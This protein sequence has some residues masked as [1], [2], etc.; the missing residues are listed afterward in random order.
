[1]QVDVSFSSAHSYFELRA[2]L[3]PTQMATA[4]VFRYPQVWIV[5]RPRAS[6]MGTGRSALLQRKTALP[7]SKKIPQSLRTCFRMS[8]LA[9][10]GERLT[11]ANTFV[12]RLSASSWC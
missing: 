1:M 10:R 6:E 8:G 2:A 11:Q 12:G 9:G 5:R 3:A 4:W 7:K